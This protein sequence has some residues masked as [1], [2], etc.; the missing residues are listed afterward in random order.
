VR[1]KNQNPNQRNN[2]SKK[3]KSNLLFFKPLPQINQK[4]EN[5]SKSEA[6]LAPCTG[7]PRAR[8]NPEKPCRRN[9]ERKGRG[10]R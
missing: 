4:K 3:N 10:K 9:I 1:K 6:R 7:I 2:N 5:E 8:K